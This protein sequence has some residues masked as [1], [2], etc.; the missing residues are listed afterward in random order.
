MIVGRNI[1][2]STD[3]SVIDTNAKVLP[4][5]VYTFI[6]DSFGNGETVKGRLAENPGIGSFVFKCFTII[7]L[8]AKAQS[9]MFRRLNRNHP[10]YVEV[11]NHP[12]PSNSPYNTERKELSNRQS[13]EPKEETCA[14]CLEKCRTK[15]AACGHYFHRAC[16][17]TWRRRSVRCPICRKRLPSFVRLVPGSPVNAIAERF[18]Y[19]RNIF[20]P[21]LGRPPRVS[22]SRYR[23]Q[24]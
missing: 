2:I 13:T 19:N 15:T 22:G 1:I 14:I 12:S 10:L 5:G 18:G 11:T 3:R 17:N 8:M 6:V 16:I 7:K 21:S 24:H 4:S 20:L 23:V 9:F